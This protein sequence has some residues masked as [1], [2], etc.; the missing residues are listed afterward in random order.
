MLLNLIYVHYFKIR[1]RLRRLSY[2]QDTSIL[3]LNENE[4]EQE[5]INVGIILLAFKPG[6]HKHCVIRIIGLE[7]Q[8]G[9][10]LEFFYLQYIVLCFAVF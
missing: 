4:G 5:K 8:S 10:V 3:V 9:R 2:S 7:W 1:L 6:S